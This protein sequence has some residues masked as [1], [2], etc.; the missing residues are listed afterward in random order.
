VKR[1]VSQISVPLLGAVLLLGVYVC[2]DLVVYRDYLLRGDE[3]AF[4][5]GSLESPAS[6]FTRG[7]FD[8]FHVYPEWETLHTSP[9]LRP[10]SNAVAYLNYSLF[11]ANYA[12]YF[13]TFFLFQFIGL[14]IFVRI[15]AELAVPPLP[16]LG[17]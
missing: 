11:G 5:I 1:L 17:M 4:I 2:Y 6:W 16:A 12:L 3:P 9:L 7:Y 14:L 15:L 13:A 10:V 8:Y